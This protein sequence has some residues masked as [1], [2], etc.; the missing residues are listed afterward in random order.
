M[1]DSPIR[2][3]VCSFTPLDIRYK[4]PKSYY[5][6]IPIL[7][8]LAL[9]LFTLGLDH[10]HAADTA[11][12]RVTVELRDGSRVVGQCL[13]KKLHFHSRLLGEIALPIQDIRLMEFPATNSA[14]LTTTAGDVLAV[15]FMDSDLAVKTSFGKVDLPVTS[16]LEVMVAGPIPGANLPG[17]VALWLGS[18]RGKDI[19]GTH[20]ASVSAGINYIEAKTGPGFFFDGGANQI[21]APNSFDLNFGPGQD[22]SIEAWIE[23][24]LQPPLMTDG[25]LPIVDKRKTPNSMQCLGYVLCLV[26]GRVGF[27]MSD[28]LTDNGGEWE[29]AGP[30]LFDGKFHQVTVTVARN[31]KDGGKI[32]VDGQLILTFDPTKYAGDL[33]NDQPLNIGGDTCPGYYAYFHGLIDNIAIYNRA[34]SPEEVKSLCPMDNTGAQLPATRTMRIQTGQPINDIYDYPDAPGRVRRRPPIP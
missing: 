31:S 15:S 7:R 3:A 23:P 16:I 1:S 34:I 26:N 11:P 8:L 25:I 2:F 9:A 13:D 6:K 24:S 21:L 18:N 5:M 33:S 20:D 14:E 19:A 12:S 28:D 30:D 17:L 29:A 22:F 27:R 32:Y 10:A 4:T